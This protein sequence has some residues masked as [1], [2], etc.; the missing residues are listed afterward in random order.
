[1]L[2]YHLVS[3]VDVQL[4]TL[5]VLAIFE[6]PALTINKTCLHSSKLLLQSKRK[7]ELYRAH[8]CALEQRAKYAQ[9]QNEQTLISA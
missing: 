4:N 3:N 2:F 7:K 6:F 1:M 8:V 5:P 9:N